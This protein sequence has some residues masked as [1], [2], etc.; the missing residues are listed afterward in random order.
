ME[1]AENEHKSPKR[2]FIFLLEGCRGF[3]KDCATMRKLSRK[4]ELFK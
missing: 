4:M 2:A 1:R 3:N